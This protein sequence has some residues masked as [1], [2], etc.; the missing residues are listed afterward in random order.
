MSDQGGNNFITHIYRGVEGEIIPDNVTRIIVDVSVRVISHHAFWE[1]ENIVEVI[2]HDG[3]EKI[4]ECA[5][6]DCHSLRRVIMPGVKIIE[7]SAFGSC[8]ALEN[9]E[10]GKLEIIRHDAFQQ[11]TRL[12]SIN[13]PSTR[14]VEGWAFW[15]CTALID[16]KF[17]SELK[18]ERMSM[19]VFSACTSLQRITIPLKDGLFD[20]AGSPFMG[21]ENLVRVDL[22]EGE[23]H[24]TIAALQLE[25]WGNDVIEEIESINQILPNADAGYYTV[26][27]DEDGDY[28]DY[29]EGEKAQAIRS[30]IRSVLGKIAHYKA[31]HERLLIEA[32]ATLQLVLPQDIAMNNIVPF[33]EL[34]VGEVEADGNDE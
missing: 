13:L 14:I 26:Y 27:T 21:C 33:L 12:R 34:P 5:F 11:C 16:M 32:A 18:L 8:E 28:D 23:V 15:D 29:D 20:D 10:C 22:V 31:E 4:E 25:E 19:G 6:L 2:C 17:G 24:T 7:R 9:V 1:H 30:W 3:V